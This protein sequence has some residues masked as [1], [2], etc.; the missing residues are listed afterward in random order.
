MLSS[1]VSWLFP[2]ASRLGWATTTVPNPHPAEARAAAYLFRGSGT[3]FSPGFGRLCDRLR[4][5]GVWAEDLRCVGD[6]WAC[7]HLVADRAVGRLVGPV[8][9]VGHSRG[10][11][12]ALAAAARLG[13]AGVAVDLVVCV[14]VAFPPPVPGNVRRA[15]HLYRSRWRAYPAR[16]LRPALAAGGRIENVDL[17]A[18]GSPTPGRGL[19]HLNITGCTALQAWVAEQIEALAGVASEQS[20]DPA[21]PLSWPTDLRK[22]EPPR[23]A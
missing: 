22:N 7:R 5:A 14:D 11:R 18:P 3:V 9:L 12:R 4:T 15:V 13:R 6:R 20:G 10:G 16:P 21:E 19:H 23:T 1:P 8:A 17:D 2:A